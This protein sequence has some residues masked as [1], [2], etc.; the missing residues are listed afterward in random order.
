MSPQNIRS[1]ET[2]IS[3]RSFVTSTAGIIAGSLG[4]AGL[5]GCA[6]D[7]GGPQMRAT[8]TP[9]IRGSDRLRV[10]L[11]GCGGRGTGAAVD[12]VQAAPGVEVVALA[13]VF[14]DRVS[15]CRAKLS[16][17]LGE[18]AKVDDAHCFS[19]FD[20]Y[21]QLMRS[22]IDLVVM[23]TPPAFRPMHLRE[24]VELGLHVF[25]EKPVAVDAVG[26]RSVIASGEIARAK[27][28]GVVSGT[29]RRH[30]SG[31][32]EC[33]RRI[34]DGAIGDVVAGGAYWIGGE[35]WM[36]PRQAE[37]TD[38]EWQLRN[39]LYFTWLSGDH[40]VEQHIHNLDVMN[41]ALR[42]HP[43][44]C[45]GMG[46]RQKRTDPAFGHIYDHFAIQYEYPG[47]AMVTSMCRQSDNCY[48]SVSEQLIGTKGKSDGWSWIQGPRTW[49]FERKDGPRPYRQEHT[50]LIESIRGGCPLNE[51]RQVAESTLTAIMGRMS[52]YTGKDV[53]WDAA[54]NSQE[55][56]LPETLE[57][58]PLPTPAVP[59]PGTSEAAPP[60]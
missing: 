35:L 49:R 36:H 20:A 3:R 54:M 27:G 56:L 2:P 28:L 31:Y 52:A 8:L 55:S 24:A 7:G 18:K 46:G 60:A 21:K 23:A 51:A 59:I 58:G 13:D 47:G 25:M 26:V 53:T 16:R 33:M 38:M 14:A 19:G 40:I 22:G 34:H 6:A 41:W 29:Q 15:E 4:A 57:F 32:I 5:T 48:S 44:R 43:L 30:H 37:W 50:D 10:G 42:S 9:H 39:W 1:D 17:S 12:A 45:F 11:V